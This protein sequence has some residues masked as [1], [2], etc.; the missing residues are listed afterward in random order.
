MVLTLYASAS[1]RQRVLRDAPVLMPRAAAARCVLSASPLVGG[2]TSNAA[3]RFARRD[4]RRASRCRV[5]VF[6]FSFSPFFADAAMPLMPFFAID[7]ADAIRRFAFIY[8]SRHFDCRY[9][10]FLRHTLIHF[11]ERLFFL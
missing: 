2:G 3:R 6:D 5:R 4:F 11:R 1:A 8:F 10:I 9:Y 7:F